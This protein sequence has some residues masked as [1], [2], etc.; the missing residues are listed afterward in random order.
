MRCLHMLDWRVQPIVLMKKNRWQDHYARQA[1]EKGWLA[2][3][4][5]KLQEIDNRYHL[6]QRGHR[7]LDL[8]CH[9]GSWSQYALKKIGAKGELIGIDLKEPESLRAPNFRFYQLDIL[10]I[11]TNWLV[12]QLGQVNVVL[13]DLAPRTSGIR[14][15]DTA[16]SMELAERALEISLSVLTANGSFLCKVFESEELRA[17][18]SEISRCFSITKAFR[19]K[20]VRKGSREIY[21]MGRKRT[22]F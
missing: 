13:S 19:P 12:S 8:G 21:V 22:I 2:R 18:R 4:I 17:F 16:R 1:K 5:F 15:A 14:S 20:A 10:T 7:V 3:S 6:I 9:P 11:D